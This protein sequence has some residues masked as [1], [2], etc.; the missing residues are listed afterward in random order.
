MDD[1]LTRLYLSVIYI[2]MIFKRL[3]SI[4]NKHQVLVQVYFTRIKPI[5]CHVSLSFTQSNISSSLNCLRGTQFILVVLQYCRIVVY[6]GQRFKFRSPSGNLVYLPSCLISR[7]VLR[8][9]GLSMGSPRARDQISWARTP[10][11]RD[12]PNITVQQFI[13]FSP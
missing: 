12:T 1:D 8:D 7:S 11:A 10:R 2:G 9:L 6:L 13:S 5:K 3:M 4:Q